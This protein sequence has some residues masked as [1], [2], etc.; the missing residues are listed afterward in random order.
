MTSV[1]SLNAPCIAGV[2]CAA[3][4]AAQI[5]GGPPRGDGVLDEAVSLLGHFLDHAHHRIVV[6]VVVGVF[7][8]TV[9]PHS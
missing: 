1:S 5:V 2:L 9:A 3:A 4:G 7:R 8:G 6:V